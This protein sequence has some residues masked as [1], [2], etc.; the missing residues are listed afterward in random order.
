MEG[1]FEALLNLIF[2][3]VLE[4]LSDT[5]GEIVKGIPE[6]LDDVAEK[7]GLPVSFSNSSEITRLNLFD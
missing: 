5:I 3:V 4:V 2:E 6:I 7:I 1:I